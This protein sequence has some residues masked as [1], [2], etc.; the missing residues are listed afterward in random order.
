MGLFQGRL[1]LPQPIGSYAL[2]SALMQI[3]PVAGSSLYS[4]ALDLTGQEKLTNA[5]KLAGAR[6]FAAFRLMDL[7]EQVR[8]IR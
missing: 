1:R 7:R 4:D 3:K 6:L 5:M 8:S 2:G